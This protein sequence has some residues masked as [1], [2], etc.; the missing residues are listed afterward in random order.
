MNP[1]IK[2]LIEISRY[3]GG[4]NEYVIAGG[5]NTSYKNEQYIWVKA[6]G[7]SLASIDENDFVKL[8]REKLRIIKTKKYSDDDVKRESEVKADLYAAVAENQLGR[9]SVETSLHEIIQY[10]FVVHTHATRING[11]LCAK[12]S[13]DAIAGLFGESVL[14]IEYTDPGYTLFKKTCERLDQYRARVGKDPQI[15]MLENHGVFVCADTAGEIRDLYKSM[16]QR[17]KKA[18]KVI[19]PKGNKPAAE[20]IKVVLPALRMLLTQQGA[21]ILRLRHN[22]LIAHFYQSEELFRRI[23]APFTPD[24]IVYCRSKYLYIDETGSPESIIAN[25]QIQLGRFQKENGYLPKVVLIKDMGLVAAEDN[26]TSAGVVLDVFEDLMKISCYS[27]GAGGPRFLTR[28]QVDFIDTWEVENYR[29]QL[30][31]GMKT[32][33]PVEHRIVIVTGAAQGF[34]EGITRDLM[35]K[36]ANIVIADINEKKGMA[37]AEELNSLG[38]K[39]RVLFVKTDVSDA[40]SVKNMLFET[41]REFGGLDVLVSNAGILRAGDLDEMDP[42]TFDLMTRV[43]YNG[44]FLCVKYAAEILKVQSKYNESYYTD[45]IQINSKSG[46][47]GS[48]KNFTYAGGKFGGIGL[49]QSFALELIPCRIK[50]NSVCPGN[51]FDGPLW[52]DPVNGLFVQYLKTGKVPGAKSIDDVKKH[53]ESQ[54]PAG[55]GCTVADVMKAIYYIIDQ[56]YETGQAVPVTGGQVMLK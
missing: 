30:A 51:F 53:Y 28:D 25:I 43:N 33:N 3:Y 18:N 47:K 42:A 1:E 10:A 14:Y 37:F 56:Q 21:K 41:V 31:G 17:L 54:I 20:K 32:T 38:K 35:E 4:N 50:V 5:G 49:T 27:E 39:N 24:I 7:T 26:W 8:S 23:H 36:N 40:V 48:N 6:S 11:L 13:K 15:I 22:E 46:L 34:G 45:I 12:N 44:Y 2:E 16:D 19:L 9:P 29:R 52:S 55:R